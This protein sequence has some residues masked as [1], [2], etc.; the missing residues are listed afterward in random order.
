VKKQEATPIQARLLTVKQAAA[1][2]A[3]S[4]FA[5]RELG[6]SRRVPSLKIGRRVLFDRTDLDTYITVAKAGAR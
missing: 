1:Y 2:L 4:V 6:W 3:C 5:V